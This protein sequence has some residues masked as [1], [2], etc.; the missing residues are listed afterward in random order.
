MTD[1][2]KLILASASPRRIELLKQI[3]PRFRVVPADLDEDSLTTTD[4]FATARSL[5]LHKAKHVSKVNLGAMVIG[6]DTVVA[7]QDQ[8]EWVQLSKPPDVADANAMLRK[9]SGRTH[10]VI[11]GFAVVGPGIE[12]S[13]FDQTRVTFRHMSDQEISDYVATGETMDKAGGY[14]SQG[15]AAVFIESIEGSLSNVIG[16]PVE[17]LTEALKT[18]GLTNR[19]E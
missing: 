14:A 10:T 18:L 9:L 11:T 16:L 2:F 6:G 4:P 1:R 19:L 17:A 5:A 3:H 13:S 12:H 8:G 15:G 7:F